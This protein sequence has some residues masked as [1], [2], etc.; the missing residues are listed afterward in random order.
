MTG[1][2]DVPER[3]DLGR[4]R[5][6]RAIGAYLRASTRLRTA[7]LR[8]LPE[9]LLTRL[10]PPLRRV[11]MGARRA[12][13]LPFYLRQR[14][15]D[16]TG[17]CDGVDTRIALWGKPGSPRQILDL[18][19][20]GE[21]SGAWR[22]PVALPRLLRDLDR[23]GSDADLVLAETTP[24]LAD[25]FARRGFLIVPARMRAGAE[26][27]TLRATIARPSSSLAS[28]LARI[29]R[30]GYRTAIWPYTR[31]RSE[32]A[33][34]RYLALH[35]DVRFGPASILSEF[36]VI[37]RLYA[38]GFVVTV[39]RPGRDEPDALG[40]VVPRGRLLW[41]VVLG[42]R[43]GMPDVLS[44]GGLA[45][46]YAAVIDVAHERGMQRIDAGCCR[47]WRTDGILRFKWKWGFRPILDGNQT[48][49]YA[50]RVRRPESAAARRLAASGVVV[51]EG[52]RFV[53]MA[54]D[55]R[56]LPAGC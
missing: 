39:T 52:S 11:L 24:A 31:A 41:F 17:R 9:P 42:T 43:D 1:E 56:L 37:D 38:A 49:E 28:D 54:P 33:Y 25:V 50:V 26:V 55:G 2:P 6:P 30:T 34:H 12:A 5:Y 35:A 21:R 16:W 8:A 32:F 4:R 18:F 53:V 20:D 10:D 45:A 29:R 22:A 36:A 13:A 46:L 51:R 47:P 44:A 23:T 14:L 7:Y 40:L 15:S 3:S 27:A 48:L 19:F